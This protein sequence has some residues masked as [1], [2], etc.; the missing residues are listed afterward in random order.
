ME[1][2][3]Y[4]RLIGWLLATALALAMVF[5]A[6]CTAT[7]SGPLELSAKDDGSTQQVEIGQ[8]VTLR[9]ESNQTTGYRWAIDGSLPEQL[10]QDGEPEYKAESGMVGAGGVETWKFKVVKGGSGELNMKYWR[11]FEPTAEPAETFS[12][13]LESK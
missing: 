13:T 3:R 5:V 8:N 10:E 7:P 1:M 9:L 2:T 6:A 11:S 4:S 12:A